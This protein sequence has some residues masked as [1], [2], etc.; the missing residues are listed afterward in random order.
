M[1]KVQYRIKLDRRLN[2]KEPKRYTE[3]LQRYKINYR[4]P[5]MSDCADKFLVR[6]FVK[7]RWLSHILNDYYATFTSY[8]DI[9]MDN[10]PDSFILKVRNGS[11]TNLIVRDKSRIT[12][13]E[14]KEI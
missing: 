10:L 4:D 3:K 6:E 13:D 7:S 11:G 8:E 1:L 5:L 2:L 14:I 12:V 9:A